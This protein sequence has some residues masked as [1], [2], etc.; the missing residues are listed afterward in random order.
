MSCEVW[1]RLQFNDVLVAGFR[2]CWQ[3]NIVPD[4]WA[5]M[6]LLQVE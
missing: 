6:G 5:D 3:F 1:A 2:G 4:E